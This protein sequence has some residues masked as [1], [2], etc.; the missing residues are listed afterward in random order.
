MDKSNLI[1][2]LFFFFVFK[3]DKKKTINQIEKYNE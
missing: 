3:I 1:E 2:V